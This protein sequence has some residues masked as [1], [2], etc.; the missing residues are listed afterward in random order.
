MGNIQ[1][2]KAPKNPI[3]KYYD[4][5]LTL[6]QCVYYTPDEKLIDVYR[7]VYNN[8]KS[9]PSDRYRSDLR[10]MNKLD[11]FRYVVKEKDV[12]EV[13][14]ILFVT[15]EDAD[16][17]SEVKKSIDESDSLMFASSLLYRFS[18]EIDDD[19]IFRLLKDTLKE[20]NWKNPCV[21]ILELLHSLRR[22]NFNSDLLILM[23]HPANCSLRDFALQNNLVSTRTLI[24][25]AIKDGNIN[26]LMYAKINKIWPENVDCQDVLIHTLTE[27]IM[28]HPISSINYQSLRILV[29][30]W[31]VNLSSFDSYLLRNII[32]LE[33][34]VLAPH[35]NELSKIGLKIN[36]DMLWEVCFSEEKMLMLRKAG[37]TVPNGFSVRNSVKIWDCSQE[38]KHIQTNLY[39]P[40]PCVSETS[41]MCI[42]C[43]SE[44]ESPGNHVLET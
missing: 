22:L 26:Y 13:L 16:K 8:Y 29:A 6:Q 36:E 35:L 19:M 14:K 37:T 31:V 41:S 12:E 38:C 15:R 5:L 43:V 1:I 17:S 2:T 21:S 32:K 34:D 11:T 10:Y 25:L 44:T 33:K 30:T 18:L 9:Y 28:V 4:G 42:P 24:D 3:E 39:E 23:L 40:V 7:A 20:S 27:C